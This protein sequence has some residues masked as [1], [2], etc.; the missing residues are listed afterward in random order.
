VDNGKTTS[1]NARRGVMIMEKV[2]KLYLCPRC[3][4]PLRK[5]PETIPFGN[6]WEFVCDKCGYRYY[7]TKGIQARE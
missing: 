7:L 5:L 6:L 1:K 2:R 3:H 4:S